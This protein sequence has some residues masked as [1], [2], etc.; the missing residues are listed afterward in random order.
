M[1][2]TEYSFNSQD[3]DVTIRLYNGIN[4]VLLT[5][6]AWDNLTLED[7]IFQYFIRGSIVINTPYDS[8]ERESPEALG[9]T[10]SK[11]EQIVYKF[12]NDGRDTLYIAIK[13]KNKELESLGNASIDLSDGKWLIELETV[14]YDVQD[15]PHGNPTDKRK[16]LYFW[17]KTY[18]M[19]LERDSE[20]TT[21]NTG[22][23]AAKQN[24]DQ[25]SDTDRSLTTG[26][27]VAALLQHHEEFKKHA[28][29]TNN[30]A[31]WNSGNENNLL[32]YTS[33]INAKFIDDLEYLYSVHT[34]DESYDNQPCILKLERATAKG[35]P[36]QFSLLPIQEYLKKAGNAIGAPGE[37]QLEHY[38][39]QENAYSNDDLMPPIQKA[40]LEKGAIK[41][42]KADDFTIIRQYQIIDFAGGDYYKNLA[43]RRIASFN[44]TAGQ[45]NIESAYHKAE[46]WKNFYQKSVATSILTK[47]PTD[48][49]PLTPYI[50]DGYNT[51]VDFSILPNNIGR[52]V[53][54]RNKMI[55]YYLFSN[56]G[57]S[58]S[59][60]GLTFRQA[61]RFFGLSKQTLND[62]EFDDKLEGQYLATEVIHHFSNTNRSYYT[63]MVGVKTHVY[64]DGTPFNSDD[65]I[66]LKG[67]S[68]QGASSPR[69][70][71]KTP[72]SEQGG[73]VEGD[74]LG[75]V[76]P[77]P[78][79]P[80]ATDPNGG[81]N[82]LL[83]PIEGDASLPVSTNGAVAPNDLR[84][85]MEQQITNS[86][87][88][89]FIPADGAKYG[90]DGTPSSWA[91]YF[92]A[93]AG[94]E[95]SYNVNT[96]GDI[97]RFV[98]NSNGLYQLSPNDAVNYRLQ[99]APFS[100][101][102]LTDPKINANAAIQIHESL[103]IRD[104]VIASNGRGASR[105]WGPLRVG[106][107]P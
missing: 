9:A 30:P 56:L 20:F 2:E 47:A 50:R 61:G 63:Q 49:L 73:S 65:L 106:W 18:Q 90:I 46:E 39:I 75:E 86:K 6:T 7:N 55:K 78:T 104:G 68:S 19:M 81:P 105:Y 97:G 72:Q 15:M 80:Q 26:G 89:G 27:A 14:I 8:L 52:L 40:P 74:L 33:P 94:K 57:I 67:S 102:Q 71:T 95:S 87:L 22:P 5:N 53:L 21:A 32:F 41:E 24:Q 64:K 51:R 58:F 17:E 77:L 84:A 4:D 91:N 96:V 29:L 31:F 38:F 11:K 16:T 60:R 48:R 23:N 98:G 10:S 28:Q 88:N 100:Q 62:K 42:I 93:L 107:T 3:Y 37:Y 66:L 44:A 45:F 34:A 103:V 76:P 43:N 85:Y 82:P 101:A 70:N 25:T 69:P 83:P 99:S 36:K 1:N 13:P 59:T 35:E 79:N 12:R 54:G 92:T